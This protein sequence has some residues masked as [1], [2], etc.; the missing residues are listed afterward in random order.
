MGQE[1]V[2]TNIQETS[3]GQTSEP[4]MPGRMN[5]RWLLWSNK[6]LRVK[7]EGLRREV[8][9]MRPLDRPKGDPDLLEIGKAFH[10]DKYPF[11]KIRPYIEETMSSVI[12]NK[13]EG[14]IVLGRN[15]N[16][17]IHLIT[18]RDRC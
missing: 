9:V 6:H 3:S 7:I 16:Y 10:F 5:W 17:S 13:N 1:I 8:L 14:V 15:R 12:E 11:V 18:S 4:L 2:S